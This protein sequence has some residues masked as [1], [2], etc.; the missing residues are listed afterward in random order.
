MKLMLSGGGTAGSVIPLLAVAAQLPEADVVFVGTVR[1][2]ERSMVPV[3]MRYVTLPAGK[4]RRYFSW[5][6]FVDPFIIAWAVVV[7]F[8]K[9]LW[10]RP[11]AILTAGSFVSVPLVWAAWWLD[12][13]VVVHQQDLTVGLANRLMAPFS[14]SLTQA[15][16]ASNFRG[17]KTV[18]NPV[19]DLTPTTD[20]IMVD[21]NY[22][23][24]L[25][26]GGST[27]AAG[28]NRLVTAQLCEQANVIHVTGAG[29]KAA[30]IEHPRYH[31]FERLD[32]EM[33]EAYAKATV[34]VCR[35]GL[36]T[37]SELAALG[38]PVVIIPMPNSHQED[39][40]D[41]VSE[42]NAAVVLDQTR[43]TAEQFTHRV[44]ALLHNPVQ[45]AT[46]TENIQQ[47]NPAD[48]AERIGAI[49]GSYESSI[50]RTRR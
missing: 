1:G 32:A 22:P 23:T 30:S 35:A 43:L 24:L 29:K 44:L 31:Q 9:L 7:A 49:V 21:I 37:I 50:G 5:R 18:G 16:A 33:A 8:V 2:V 48:A 6:N 47:L 34:V 3:D 19:R 10:Y 17:A 26:V 15:F 4:W 13:P 40:A 36:G 14:T 12:I 38:K 28:I 11:N 45:Q 39:N 25:I 41:F 27:G 46:L 20:S 42:Y